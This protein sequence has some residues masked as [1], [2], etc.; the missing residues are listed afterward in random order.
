L[1]TTQRHL[2]CV[3]FHF[4]L[5]QLLGPLGH[6]LGRLLT[7]GTTRRLLL[8]RPRL[9]IRSDVLFQKKR[10]HLLAQSARQPFTLEERHQLILVALSEHPLEGNASPPKKLLPQ[11]FPILAAQI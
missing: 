2:A 4:P 3:G 5:Q 1:L 9:P 10:R 6:T 7:L 11:S 8:R